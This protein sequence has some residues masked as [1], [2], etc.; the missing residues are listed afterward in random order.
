M[1][2]PTTAGLTSSCDRGVLVI[3]LNKPKGNVLDAAL[4][5]ELHDTLFAHR[6]D[7]SL[8]MVLLQAVG[9][10]FS[11]GAA[12]DEHLPQQAP[13]MLRT[14]HAL[15]RQVASY[16]VPVASLVQGRCMG[17]AFELV[18]CGHLLFVRPDAM[19]SCP[20]VQLAVFPPVLAAIGH[21]RL[22][23]PLAE[24]M[25]LTGAALDA[26]AATQCGLATAAVAAHD[27]TGAVF[28]WYSQHLQALSA[29]AVRQAVAAVR[30][31]SGLLV[32]LGAGLD[33]AEQQYL[34]HVLPSRD[35]QEG[36]AAFLARRKPEWTHA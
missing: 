2:T 16:P 11:F 31:G 20:E 15:C 7:L 34:E 10:H 3:T 26:D 29:Y 1:T 6:G 14:F 24:K 22:G 25:L 23:G 4:M 33:A 32:A 35:G 19:L 27:A 9:P 21:L 13:A 8:K 12:V 5:R 17:G 18:L 36:I 28:A 30:R